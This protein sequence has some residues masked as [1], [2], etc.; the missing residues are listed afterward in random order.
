M[1]HNVICKSGPKP[2]HQI[3]KISFE[4]SKEDEAKWPHERSVYLEGAPGLLLN[5]PNPKKDQAR[6]NKPTSTH[7]KVRQN[8]KTLK[9]DLVKF[10]RTSA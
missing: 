9:F 5:N 3:L 8:I 2:N 10:C 7:L 1:C 4:I 6:T